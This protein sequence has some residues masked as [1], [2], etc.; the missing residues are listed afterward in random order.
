MRGFYHPYISLI[1]FVYIYTDV[2]LISSVGWVR[3]GFCKVAVPT[4][5]CCLGN[6]L[7]KTSH[8]YSIYT[9]NVITHK[10]S[11]YVNSKLSI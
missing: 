8:S 2:C 10:S 11:E 1:S 6:L 5:H 7:I 4:T 9:L 3:T